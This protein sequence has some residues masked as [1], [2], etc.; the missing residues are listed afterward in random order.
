MER[1]VAA[2][3]VTYNRQALLKQC[4]QHLLSQTVPCTILLVDNASTDGTA[5]W[6]QALCT[7]NTRVR[8]RNTGSNLGGAGGFSFGIEWACSEDFEFLWLMDDDTLPE[9][10]ALEKFLNADRL[11]DGQYGWLS[12][13]ALWKDGHECQ[14]NRQKV[15][16]NFYEYSQFLR[17]GLLLAE[18][19]TFVSLFLRRDVV[20][21]V[22]LPIQEFFIW[23]DDI[24]YTRRIAVRYGLPG[25]VA[26]K[27]RVVHAMANNNG[28]NI[29]KDGTERI[30]R[31]RYAFRN[32]NY[33][34]RQEGF[35]GFCY[36]FAKCGKNLLC[37]WAQAPDHKL[38]R[39]GIVLGQLFAGL[40]FNPKVRFPQTAA[41]EPKEKE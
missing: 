39:S 4:V 34:Y 5:D 40:F 38:K 36:Y 16:K 13:V 1:K 17:E 12:G 32:E 19:A 8:Y 9:P 26:G 2:I 14:M 37:I 11:L 29:A 41:K 6:A 33:L 35:K 30:D 10:E 25:F 15:R 3:V 7:Q 18:Q 31:Y 27:S 20:H 24:E 28:S 23:G 21:L 22:G